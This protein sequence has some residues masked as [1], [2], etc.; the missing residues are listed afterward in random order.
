LDL[1]R[2]IMRP[3]L[4]TLPY[5]IDDARHE[6][7]AQPFDLKQVAAPFDL[8]EQ[9]APFDLRR[10]KPSDPPG[11]GALPVKAHRP[12]RRPMVTVGGLPFVI[13]DD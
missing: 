1:T 3:R 12:P 2:T 11:P 4:P 9:T 6:Q 7:D 13:E 5:P 10:V 8:K